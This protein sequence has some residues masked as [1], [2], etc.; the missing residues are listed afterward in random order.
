MILTEDRATSRPPDA[1]HAC[2]IGTEELDADDGK[3]GPPL[4]LAGRW[5]QSIRKP[6]LRSRSRGHWHGCVQ[7]P[8]EES[9]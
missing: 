1:L 8:V 2:P 5:A 7:M 9:G 4:N 6:L 3:D